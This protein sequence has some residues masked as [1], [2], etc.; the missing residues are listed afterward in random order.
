VIVVVGSPALR[1][2]EAPGEKPQAAGIAAQIAA[3]AVGA[4]GTVQFVGKVGEDDAGDALVLAFARAG[5]GHAALQRDAAMRTPVISPEA[6][7]PLDPTAEPSGVSGGP[8]RIL[9]GTAP[10]EGADIDLALRY[11]TDFR[12]IVL[13]QPVDPAATRVLAD[14]VEYSGVHLILALPPG[15]AG[16]SSTDSM[17]VLEAPDFDSDGAFPKLV[18]SYAAALDRGISPEKAFK[19]ALRESGWEPAS[20]EAI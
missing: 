14:A 18:G 19:D 16:A 7:E 10:L 12:V 2:P 15:T 1:L 13:A 11:L 8:A 20:S 6:D 9:E 4:G 3:S 5:L 17:T